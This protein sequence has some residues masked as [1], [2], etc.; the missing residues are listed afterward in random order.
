MTTLPS[1]LYMLNNNTASVATRQAIANYFAVTAPQPLNHS[2][3]VGGF[4]A[5][6][7]EDEVVNGVFHGKRMQNV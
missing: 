1:Q 5:G 2:Q 4:C 3:S 6:G 7:C